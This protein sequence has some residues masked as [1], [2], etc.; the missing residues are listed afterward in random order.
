MADELV[1][2]NASL[3]RAIKFHERMA[4]KQQHI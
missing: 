3:R 1:P 2:G 4:E